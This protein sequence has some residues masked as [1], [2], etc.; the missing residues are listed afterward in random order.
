M[1]GKPPFHTLVGAAAVYFAV[2]RDETPVPIDYPELPESDPLWNLMRGCWS[3]NPL[4]R[5]TVP[6][7]IY[8]VGHWAIFAI[9]REI[10]S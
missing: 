9:A 8:K 2:F 10:E 1:S 5:P 6:Q 7:I 4:D 3:P